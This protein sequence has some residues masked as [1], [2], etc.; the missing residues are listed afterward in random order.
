MS[1]DCTE[2]TC[3]SDTKAGAPAAKSERWAW[4]LLIIVLLIITAIRVR[5]LA[6]PLERD[7]GEFAYMGQLMLDGIPPYKIAY[8]MKLPGIYAAY[9]LVMAVFGQTIVGVHLGLL[10]VNLTAI[11]LLFLLVKRL[12]DPLAGVVASTA[13]GLHSLGACTFGSSAHATHFVLPFVLGGSLLLLRGIESGKTRMLFW[14]GLLLGIGVLMK[15]HAAVFIPFAAIYVLWAQ[16]R[17]RPVS[18]PSAVKKAGLLLLGAVIPFGL[19]CLV[20]YALGVFEKFW[21]WT[22]T[23]A[24]EY[25]SE[26]TARQ[27]WPTFWSEVQHAWMGFAWLWLIGAVGL[28][29]LFIDDRLKGKRA[30]IGGFALFTFLMACPG[31]YFRPHYFIPFI[32]AVAMLGGLAVSSSGR[33][34]RGRIRIIPVMCMVLALSYGVISNWSYWFRLNPTEAC[35]LLYG[36]NPFPEAIEVAKF[37]REGTQDDDTIA[38]LGSEPE[39][40]FYAHRR[41]ATGYIYTYGLMEA[42]KHAQEMQ[43]EVIR[44]VESAH[45][46]YVVFVAM[47]SSW[48]R[49]SKSKTAIFDWANR[50]LPEKY[51]WVGVVD[52]IIED[53]IPFVKGEQAKEY[54]P[55]GDEYL[56]IVKRLD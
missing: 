34:L 49:Y 13:Y 3:K 26:R 28:V 19:T 54:E 16:M 42:Q 21:F 39:I 43:E 22:F 40:Y 14:S 10:L 33:A 4:V 48:L 7:E 6:V 23:Y 20:M 56:F 36:R 51:E 47:G 8:S 55:E 5:L 45:P 25:T 1:T 12:I 38:V 32:S 52:F 11:L 27:I 46:K 35:R 53:Y 50:Y 24:S 31:F 37:I 2:M 44:Q 17:I 9:A 15:Q 18:R 30:F 29:F 41:A